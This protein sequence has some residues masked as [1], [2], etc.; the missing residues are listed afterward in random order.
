MK[1]RLGGLWGAPDREKT[2]IYSNLRLTTH[3]SIR[4]LELL[5]GSGREEII[6]RLHVTE[7][8]DLPYEALSYSWGKSKPTQAIQ[9]ND[10][11]IQVRQNLLAGLYHLR[12]SDRSRFLWIDALW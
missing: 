4:V 7:F 2:D 6:T 9:C 12:Y 8:H 3:S 1:S 10:R 5:P 11:R